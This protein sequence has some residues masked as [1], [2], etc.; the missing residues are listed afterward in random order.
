MQMCGKK[1][2]LMGSQRR[3]RWPNSGA[4]KKGQRQRGTRSGGMWELNQ[5]ISLLTSFFAE[6]KFLGHGEQSTFLPRDA[7]LLIWQR[8]R[9][10]DTR[11]TWRTY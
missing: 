8:E 11:S 9:S 5:P 1:K 10:R 7:P 3:M 4:R 6:F 2:D